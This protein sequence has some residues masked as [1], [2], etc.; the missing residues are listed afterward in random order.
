MPVECC[1]FITKNVMKHLKV[2]IFLILFSSGA[3]AQEFA[4]S[5]YNNEDNREINFEILGKQG[6]NY[7]IYKNVRWKHMLAFY[8]ENMKMVKSFRLTYVSDKT[9]NVDFITYPD[10]FY[11]IYQYQK[12]NVIYC[13]AVK[14]DNNGN[15][16]SGPVLLDTGKIWP[17]QD[18]RIYTTTYSE[19]KQ[20]I[21]IYKRQSFNSRMTLTTKLY[22]SDL[23]MEDSTSRTFEY[24]DRYDIFSDMVVDNIGGMLMGKG[25]LPAK[26]S[27][28]SSVQLLLIPFRHTNSTIDISL[29]KNFIDGFKVKVDNRNKQYIISAL[30]YQEKNG[31]IKGL[32]MAT[33]DFS[34][35]NK[36]RTAFQLFD[37]SL[38]NK[39][40]SGAEFQTAFNNLSLKNIVITNDGGFIIAGENSYTQTTGGY[41]PW[42]RYDSYGNPVYSP[43]DYNMMNSG[44]NSYYRP[45]NSNNYLQNTRYYFEDIVLVSIDKNLKVNWA[46]T[47]PKKQYDDGEDNYMSFSMLNSGKEI[48]FLFLEKEKNLEVISNHSVLPHGEFKRYATLKSREA[49]YQFMPKLAKQISA[50]QVIIPCVYRGYICF[51]KVD[52][53]M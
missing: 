53:E 22:N 3:I 15:K 24:D 25:K 14:L 38:R 21:L 18:E 20:H 41:S 31:N 50:T 48:H 39:I 23:I 4:Y 36:L 43:Y 37:D 9:F 13:K 42:Q 51:A 2:L 7:V 28:L 34:D 35:E 5:D 12:N 1:N 45:S 27:S 19:N 44:F 33:V 26:K 10:Y 40:S 49:G 17:R 16:L 30:Y 52:F 32:F 29:N 6:E 11:M 46:N 8:N 47:I